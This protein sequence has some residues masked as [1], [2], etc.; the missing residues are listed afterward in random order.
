MLYRCFTYRILSC[1][2]LERKR[3]FHSP[4]YPSRP[5]LLENNG[6]ILLPAYSLFLLL[7]RLYPGGMWFQKVHWIMGE[8]YRLIWLNFWKLCPTILSPLKWCTGWQFAV[9]LLQSTLWFMKGPASGKWWQCS[10]L[11]YMAPIRNRPVLAGQWFI[12]HNG[13]KK[14]WEG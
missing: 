12:N 4:S 1:V 2:R 10:D 3:M 6:N 13:N 5:F 14:G 11:P 8:C 9:G 7:E